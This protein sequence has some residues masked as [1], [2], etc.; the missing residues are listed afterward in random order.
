LTEAESHR[1]GLNSKVLK[2]SSEEEL[3]FELA[4]DELEATSEQV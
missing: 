1:Q 4:K 3:V 2:A